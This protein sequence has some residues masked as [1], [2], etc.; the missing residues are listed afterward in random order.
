MGLTP[1]LLRILSRA[2]SPSEALACAS[3]FRVDMPTVSFLTIDGWQEA[4]SAESIDSPV[5]YIHFHFKTS[6][7]GYDSSRLW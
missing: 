5:M 7:N 3:V 2:R 6:M 1:P 4:S